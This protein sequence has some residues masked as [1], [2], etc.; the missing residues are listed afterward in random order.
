MKISME[1]EMK[2]KKKVN[3]SIEGLKKSLEYDKWPWP[4]N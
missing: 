3:H 2:T 4:H 1:K